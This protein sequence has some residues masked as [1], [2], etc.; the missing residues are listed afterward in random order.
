MKRIYQKTAVLVA[1]ILLIAVVAGVAV[2][3]K[4]YGGA[5]LCLPFLLYY[6][7]RL[8]RLNLKTTAQ[9]HNFVESFR[10]SENNVAFHT[11]VKDKLYAGFYASI[12]QAVAQFN[13]ITQK[14]EAE[15][16]FYHNLLN[17]IDFALVVADEQDRITWI[18]KAALDLFGRPKPK[19][20]ADFRNLSEDLPETFRSLHSKSGRTIKVMKEGKPRNIILNLSTITIRGNLLKVFSLKDVQPVVE[21]AEGSAW[22]ELVR[23][24]T[25]EMM[26]SLTPIISLSDTFSDPEAECD[27]ETMSK[28]ML[29]IHRR[30]QGLVDFVNNYKKLSQ[31]PLPRRQSF[32]IK[33]L[34]EDVVGLMEA[35]GIKVS[36]LVTSDQILLNAD[37]GQMEQVLINLVK[38]AWEACAGN[39]YPD[40]RISVMQETNAPVSIAVS[41]NGHGIRPELMDK[42]FIPFYTTKSKGSGIGL[43]ICRQIVISH[44]GI[45]T[46]TSLP[47]KGT[48]FMI[49][50]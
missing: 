41:D 46:A 24:L 30:S 36:C 42:I 21:A 45:L 15:V 2:S 12:E 27:P 20:I 34:L 25:H 13:A 11:E 32:A 8:Y 22:Q 7:Y 39:P 3:L 49:R 28:A 14:R 35:Q 38:N 5:L 1:V 31:L 23:V 48:T 10:F 43:S 19:Y 9:F 17:R 18:N 29:T 6:A 37:R 44:G 4:L 40:I 33:G 26:N 50:F 47:D 16:S